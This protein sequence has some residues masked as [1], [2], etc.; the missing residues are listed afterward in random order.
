MCSAALLTHTLCACRY[1]LHV[2]LV[3]HGKRCPR[4]AK[5]RGWPRKEPVGECP[6]KMVQA[7]PCDKEP[8]AAAGTGKPAGKRKQKT[9]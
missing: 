6:L 1:E 3:E 4:C 8:S 9:T 5:I 7:V 2:L